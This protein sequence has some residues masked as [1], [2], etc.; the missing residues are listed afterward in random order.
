MT[1]FKV[2]RP[3][4]I[5]NTELYSKLKK[6]GQ[7]LTAKPPVTSS[8]FCDYMTELLGYNISHMRDIR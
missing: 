3:T 5:V 2:H 8:L 6:Y 1:I 7:F 4:T